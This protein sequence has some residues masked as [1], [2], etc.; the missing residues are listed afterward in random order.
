MAISETIIRPG[1]N[2]T[3]S[4]ISSINSVDWA[5]VGNKPGLLEA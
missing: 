2:P 3:E 4:D 5:N 1:V